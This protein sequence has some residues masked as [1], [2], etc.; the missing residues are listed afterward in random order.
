[1]QVQ[2]IFVK[3][4]QSIVLKNTISGHHIEWFGPYID[5][6]VHHQYNVIDKYGRKTSW[7]TSQYTEN[8]IINPHIRSI[9]IPQINLKGNHSNG[10]Y[11]LEVV[12]ITKANEG[13]YVCD[14]LN[15]TG[16]FSSSTDAFFVQTKG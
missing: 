5:T 14:A 7:N 15:I 2:L 1:M 4:G 11:L 13:L 9:G 6:Y 3:S 16:E 10:E 8:Q 12:N